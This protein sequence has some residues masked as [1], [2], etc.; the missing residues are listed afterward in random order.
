[1]TNLSSGP[2]PWH[3]ENPDPF[4]INV[5]T[6]FSNLRYHV[7][8]IQNLKMPT[9]LVVGATGQQGSS[10]VKALRSSTHQDVKLRAMTRNP[11]SPMINSLRQQDIEIVKADLEDNTSLQAALRGCDAAYLVTDFRGPGD[12]QG[13]IEQGK[14]FIRAAQQ[15]GKDAIF[16]QK[17]LI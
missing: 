6:S 13:E 3:S 14:N 8:L 1:M 15:A 2:G 7:K 11:Q 10:V 4:F 12:V 9:F 16:F 17:S 5:A